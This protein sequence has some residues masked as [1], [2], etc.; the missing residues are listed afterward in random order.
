MLHLRTN[1]L[2]LGQ[3]SKIDPQVYFALRAAGEVLR[4]NGD[5]NAPQ[6]AELIRRNI[7]APGFPSFGT[8]KSS[9]GKVSSL[10]PVLEFVATVREHPYA[11]IATVIAIPTVAF[12]LGR[13]SNKKR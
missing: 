6:T 13:A 9:V 7:E 3:S 8:R 2:A 12:L 11:T 1:A 10:N 4:A 5:P